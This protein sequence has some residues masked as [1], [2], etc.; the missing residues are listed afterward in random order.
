MP[1]MGLSLD[2]LQSPSVDEVRR[3][4]ASMPGT[5]PLHHNF[6]RQVMCRCICSS[7]RLPGETVVQRREVPDAVQD[8]VHHAA[9]KENETDPDVA[10]NCR[11]ILNLHTISKMLERLLMSR[12]R[13]RVEISTNFN[14]FQ[15]AYRRAHTTETTLLRMLNDEHITADNQ[16]RSL[17][18]QFDLFAAF[19]TIDK[20]TLL[21][22]LDH[23]FGVQ[24][25]THK[26]V[27]SMPGRAKSVCQGRQ[28]HF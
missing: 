19:D 28:S 10:S 9:A 16:S 18:M 26:C 4:I 25:T 2:K 7:N 11:P 5:C 1:F 6:R 8:R 21:I 12:I 20:K 15:S 23:S 27:N 22:R 17:I 13:S 24:G 3:L 14:R